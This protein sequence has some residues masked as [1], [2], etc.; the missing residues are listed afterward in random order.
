MKIGD[1]VIILLTIVFTAFISYSSLSQEKTGGQL[2]IRV[3]HRNREIMTLATDRE[4]SGIHAFAFDGK[5]AFLEIDQGAV[6]LLPMSEDIC[7]RQIC[8][9]VGWANRKGDLLVCLPN[10]L[11]VEIVET[12]GEA[13][14]GTDAFSY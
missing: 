14:H 10:D 13:D 12:K 8:S 2:S 3:E 11:I 6:R 5:E 4:Y 9:R 1:V 7:P